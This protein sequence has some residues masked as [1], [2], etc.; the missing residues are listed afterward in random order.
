MFLNGDN[1]IYSNQYNFANDTWM[2]PNKNFIPEVT[3][4]S[5]ANYYDRPKQ[6]LYFVIGGGDQDSV[7]FVIVQNCALCV[8]RVNLVFSRS[9]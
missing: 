9:Y 6:M 2:F 5:G 8:S 4:S 7:L 3:D 1:I